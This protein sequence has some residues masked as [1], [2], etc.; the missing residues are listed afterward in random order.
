MD[1]MKARRSVLVVAVFATATISAFA[2]GPRPSADP[3]GTIELPPGWREQFWAGDDA[4]AVLALDSKA[5]A[6]LVPEQA[7]LRFCRCPACP[8][9][10]EDDTL[11]WSLSAKDVLKCRRCGATFPNDTI[12][13][14]KDNKVP[15]ERVEVRPGLFHVYPYHLVPPETQ[16]Y[17]DERIYVGAKRDY[18]ARE[19]L[20]KVALYAAMNARELR[21]D[22]AARPFARV[23]CDLLIRFAQVYPNY[24]THYD[25]PNEPKFFLP[26][27][28]PPPYRVDYKTAK[29]DWTASLNVPLN[30]A[31]AYAILRDDPAMDAAAKALNIADPK[32]LIERDLFRGSA[33]FVASQP[34]GNG[35][36]ALI[37]ARGILAVG[38][39]LDDADLM[40]R[41]VLQ[42]SRLASQ[43]FSN[44][45]RWIEGD[46][47]AQRRVLA[48]LDGWID[49]LLSGYS[50]RP[51]TPTRPGGRY[52]NLPG[53]AMI[54]RL[55]LVRIAS[56]ASI[57]ETKAPEVL[58]VRWPAPNEPAVS[59]TAIL[60]GGAGIARLSVGQGP[61][62]LDLELRGLVDHGQG[63]SQRLALR[64]AVGGTPILDDHEDA[65]PRADGWDRS[66]ASQ[67]TVL[68]DG[69]NQRELPE[70]ARSTVSP[71]DVA[72]FAATPEFQVATFEDRFAYPRASTLY[73]RTIVAVS[74]AM[75][76]YAVSVF[77]VEG[78]LQH[79]QIHHAAASMPRTWLLDVPTTIGPR[80]LLPDSIKFL[81][82]AKAEDGRWFVQAMGEFREIQHANLT[83]PTSAT[84][85]AAGGPGLRLHLLGDTPSVLYS[86]TVPRRDDSPERAAL[87]ERR[88]SAD[89]TTLKSRFVTL[90]EPLPSRLGPRRY[91]RVQNSSGTVL[92]VRSSRGDESLFVNAEPGVKQIVSL[93]DGVL[94]T[95]ADVVRVVDG[96]VTMA[97]GTVA[98]LNGHSIARVQVTGSITAS[99][100]PLVGVSRGWFDTETAVDPSTV[101][102]GQVVR[103]QLPDKSKRAWTLSRIEPAPTG[104]GSRIWVHE[105]PGIHIVS[106][107]ESATPAAS[108]PRF[109]GPLPF[110]IDGIGRSSDPIR[111]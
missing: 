27:D 9:T 63:R 105:D 69:L 51:G 68:I 46:D 14:K 34:Q 7:G 20:S 65:V 43:S 26:A 33:D 83:A 44:D 95:D 75:N 102:A 17:L 81:P 98:T 29:W 61:D 59:R 42:L 84:I 79:E 35:E 24:A 11:S 57:G 71:S 52:V 87:I 23:G 77:D 56:A 103:I 92:T 78:G 66:T 36:S 90:F 6:A 25:Q 45:G 1:P 74:D 49:R 93:S 16:H 28:L 86:A 15:E 73:R 80:T 32:R 50:D 106:P 96:V 88:R 40:H 4:K 41:G 107:E 104:S 13:A 97:G 37:A 64:V 39:L 82:S 62:S 3:L 110:H 22:P 54:P 55:S 21:G 53:I 8:A 108:P 31:I 101:V 99:S 48:M 76:R 47:Q 60:L 85:G 67:N 89:G 38:R 58:Q 109:P 94:E 5:V 10:E 70:L 30:L 100:G 18:E 12:P 72:F 111:R 2:A 91:G 19:W